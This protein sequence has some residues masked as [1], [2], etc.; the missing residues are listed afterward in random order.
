MD[1]P[2]SVLETGVKK[3]NSLRA[4]SQNTELKLKSEKWLKGFEVNPTW[5]LF[6]IFNFSILHSDLRF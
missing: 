4:L 3:V 6:S 2:L 1:I 5:S